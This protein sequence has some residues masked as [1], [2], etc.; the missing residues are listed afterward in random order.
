MTSAPHRKI[1][2]ILI[3]HKVRHTFPKRKVST[4]L[5]TFTSV[6]PEHKALILYRQKQRMSAKEPETI[7]NN[8]DVRLIHVPLA[9][10]VP[11]AAP[12]G[13]DLALPDFVKDV[14]GMTK[15]EDETEKSIFH[16]RA[17]HPDI[18]IG[19]TALTI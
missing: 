2:H 17:K 19:N 10:I 3:E 12:D 13:R 6:I 18:V 4:R 7:G 8:F 16:M 1:D 9:P 15:I 11:M 5:G 14:V